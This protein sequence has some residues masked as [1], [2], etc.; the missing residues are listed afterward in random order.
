MVLW[1]YGTNAKGIIGKRHLTSKDQ[2][3]LYSVAPMGIGVMLKNYWQ[4][5]PNE[6]RSNQLIQRWSDG[7]GTNAKGIVGKRHLASKIKS[8]YYNI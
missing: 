6:Y 5:P 7:H 4:A 2:I 8:I 1:A 3:N